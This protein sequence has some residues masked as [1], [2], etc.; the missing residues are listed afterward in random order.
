MGERVI[1]RVLDGRDHGRGAIVYWNFI[2]FFGSK[3]SVGVGIL[4]E[5]YVH[6]GVGRGCD[7]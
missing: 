5:F 7:F 2:D 6:F 1:D 3:G 4:V